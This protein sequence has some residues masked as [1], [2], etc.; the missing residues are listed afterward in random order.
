MRNHFGPGGL[1][2]WP[3]LRVVSAAGMIPRERFLAGVLCA[4]LGVACSSSSSGGSD[5][6]GTDGPEAGPP[7]DAFASLVV[8]PGPGDT[9]P[10]ASVVNFLS[11]GMPTG[12][13]P[14]TILD[15]GQAAGGTATVTCSVHPHGQGFDVALNVSVAG[16]GGGALTIT[17]PAGAGAIGSS[18]GTGVTAA[19]S[20]AADG[21]GLSETGCTIT[22]EYMGAPVPVS[23]A[24]AAGRIWGHLACPQ[25]LFSGG[26]TALGPDGGSTPASCAASG[27]FLFENC[28]Q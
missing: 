3:R 22:F 23:P 20:N 6:K 9:C 14:T 10:F 25:A 19:F 8:G 26:R 11:I 2:A 16:P 17:S 13:K 5:G 18:G 12:E 28:S 15:Q 24:V 21:D 1:V 27:D 7:S 4:V